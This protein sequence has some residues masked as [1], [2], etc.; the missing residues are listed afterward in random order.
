LAI[1]IGDLLTFGDMPGGCM[2]VAQG[3]AVRVNGGD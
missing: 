1:F 2:L 3:S